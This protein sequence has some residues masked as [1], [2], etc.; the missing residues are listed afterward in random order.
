MR[1]ANALLYKGNHH[2][3]GSLLLLL[4]SLL[5]DRVTVRPLAGLCVSTD[6]PPVV[7]LAIAD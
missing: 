6:W 1:R 3:H 4:L 7:G 2:D 5:A